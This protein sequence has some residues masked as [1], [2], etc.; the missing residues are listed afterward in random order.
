[1]RNP[2]DLEGEGLFG[3]RFEA[4]HRGRM[5]MGLERD[6]DRQ[7]NDRNKVLTPAQAIF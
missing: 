1:M 6:L 7:Q 5:N 3:E 2:F 4:M